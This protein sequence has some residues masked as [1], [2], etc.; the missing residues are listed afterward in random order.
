MT[1]A[2][3]GSKIANFQPKTIEKP[4]TT[5]A[6]VEVKSFRPQQLRG[7]VKNNYQQI[8]QQ[9]GNLASTDPKSNPQFKLHPES[10]KHLGIDQEERS[11]LEGVVQSEVETRMRALQDRAY[12]E[13]F[14]K[15][16][17]DGEE[18]AKSGFTEKMQPLFDQ[19]TLLLE[20]FEGIKGKLYLA[21]ESFLV[22][23][24][25]NIAKQILLQDLKKDQD[26]IKR[27]TSE[28][29]E[30]VGAKDQVRVKISRADFAN[31][32]SV[33]DFLKTQFPELKN[34]Y[35]EASDEL[36]LGGCKVETDL[37]RVNASV[38]TQLNAIQVALGGA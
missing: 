4:S 9:F 28:I 10:K 14:Q 20:E 27:L 32:E 17:A 8:T 38:E 34:L 15:G 33:R 29:I 25:F 19:F 31:I 24:I 37:S 16:L 35:I 26:Y 36:E 22:Q 13:G 21:N 11:H 3:S 23:M 30:K 1:E 7:E 12:A 18:K 2:G 6:G 5:P